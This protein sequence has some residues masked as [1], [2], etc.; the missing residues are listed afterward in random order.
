MYSDTLPFLRA[1]ISDPLRVGAV[2]PSGAALA[3]LIT[4]EISEQTGRVLEL[5]PGT[6]V[7][8]RALLSRGVAEKNL[9]LV[10]YD[11]H[12]VRVLALRFPEAQV[13]QLDAADLYRAR[14]SQISA[15][16]AAISGLP[17]LAFPKNKVI[18]IL[19]GIFAC[20][21]PRGALY[22][23]TYGSGCPV[24]RPILD[25]LH[26][27]AVRIGGTLANLPPATVY[28]ITRRPSPLLFRHTDR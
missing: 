15:V 12:F 14:R 7:F 26:L 17:L 21:E 22:Q 6:G 1:W 19:H 9:T 28:R 20:L 25:R 4:S 18:R 16:R 11:L 24:P 27:K 13:L 3:R 2:A 8:T 23:F 5:G 10:E